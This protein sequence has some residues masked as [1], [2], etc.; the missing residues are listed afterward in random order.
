M[1]LLNQAKNTEAQI[2]LALTT[3]LALL[4]NYKSREIESIKLS[5]TSEW[6]RLQAMQ[7]LKLKY[8]ALEEALVGLNTLGIRPNT[9]LHTIILNFSDYFG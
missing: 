5:V 7:K 6:N 3:D 2:A 1:N 8:A 9:S 4:A